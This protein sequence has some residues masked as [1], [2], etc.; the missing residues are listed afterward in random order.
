MAIDLAPVKINGLDKKLEAHVRSAIALP[1]DTG[2]TLQITEGRL[3]YYMGSL[4]ALVEDSLEPMGFYDVRVDSRLVRN[5][6]AAQI[7]IDIDLGEP[8]RVRQSNLRVDGPGAND[9]II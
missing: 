8:V 1:E 7:I 6:D 4:D 5:G 3:S 2:K 9:R